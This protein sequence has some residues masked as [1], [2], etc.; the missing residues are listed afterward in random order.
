MDF[1]ADHR[2]AGPISPQNTPATRVERTMP[3]NSQI[4][5]FRKTSFNLLVV[6]ERIFDN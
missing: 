1:V 6:L 2:K 3:M 5:K 4:Y